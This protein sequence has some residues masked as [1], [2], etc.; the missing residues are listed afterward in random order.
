MDVAA[1]VMC[2]G[3]L[4]A[5]A[6]RL[7]SLLGTPKLLARLMTEADGQEYL[8]LSKGADL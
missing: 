1:P 5:P 8:D 3:E 7:K 6:H 4:Y 2:L